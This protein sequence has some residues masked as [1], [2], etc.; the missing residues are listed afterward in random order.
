MNFGFNRGREFEKRETHAQLLLTL[1]LTD[2]ADLR[3]ILEA[4][5]SELEGELGQTAI[6]DTNFYVEINS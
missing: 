5:V 1:E 4:W 2:D 6:E 3:H